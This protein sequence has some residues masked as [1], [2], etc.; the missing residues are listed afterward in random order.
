MDTQLLARAELSIH[1]LATITGISRHTLYSWKLGR[2]QI[3]LERQEMMD[4]VMNVIRVGVATNIFPLP[5][6]KATR[7][8]RVAR[9]A[10][11]VAAFDLAK[12]SVLA[13]HT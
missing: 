12:A 13:S 6:G 10:A 3:S 8:N 7:H 1:D 5:T 4:T 2:A 9:E 11:V